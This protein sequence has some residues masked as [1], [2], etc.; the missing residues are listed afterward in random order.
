MLHERRK[1]NK[2]DPQARKV[3]GKGKQKNERNQREKQT[4]EGNKG[5]SPTSQ[6]LYTNRLQCV[7]HDPGQ[8]RGYLAI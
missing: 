8:L 1:L 5:N 4:K 7:I 6:G 3:G 2:K